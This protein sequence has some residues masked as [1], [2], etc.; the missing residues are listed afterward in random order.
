MLRSRGCRRFY[1]LVVE[2]SSCLCGRWAVAFASSNFLSEKKKEKKK[3]EIKFAYLGWL[4][5]A[6]D[7]GR[8]HFEGCL[9]R[10][11]LFHGAGVGN[12]AHPGGPG[13]CKKQL[14]STFFLPEKT[15]INSS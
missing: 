4:A 7:C 15:Q 8:N 2:N 12:A 14:Y 1:V 5:A 13:S 6:N 3:N 11:Q 10:I 9:V